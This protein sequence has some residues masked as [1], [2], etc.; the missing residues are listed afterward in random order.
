MG[1]VSI[2]GTGGAGVGSDECTA[3]RADLLK[4]YTAVTGD[5]DDEATEGTLEL[6]GDAADSQVLAGKT[7]YNTN[8]KFKRTGSMVNQGA[9]S[10]VLNA[11]GSYTVPSGYHNGSGKVTANSLT[12]QTPGSASAGHILSGQTAWVN[13]SKLTGNIPYQNAD[14]SGTD[15]AWATNISCWEGVAC[16]GVRNAHYLNGVNWIQGNISNFYA[17]NIK[18]GVNMGG[19]VGT[20]EGYVANP[21][22]WYYLGANPAGFTSSAPSGVITF[23]SNQIR[24]ERY[25][26]GYTV[27]SS[28]IATNSYNLTGYSNLAIAVSTGGAREISISLSVSGF[29]GSVGPFTGTTTVYIPLVNANVTGIPTISVSH[30]G[31]GSVTTYITR[32]WLL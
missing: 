14:V 12:S 21:T 8:P 3:T 18:K 27:T 13:G 26:Q 23:E 15:R 16:L 6:T 19:L 17:G 2:S 22:D 32:I 4:G 24:I 7:Y 31:A 1:K 29:S 5:S 9:V 10:Q 30:A 20:F 28:L 11:G 25:S